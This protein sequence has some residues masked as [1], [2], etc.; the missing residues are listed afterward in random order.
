MTLDPKTWGYQAQIQADN[1]RLE[2]LQTVKQRHQA[3]AGALSLDADGHGTIS[4]PE[5]TATVKVSQLRVQEQT[6]QGLTL[7]ARIHDQVAEINLSSEFAQTPLKGNGT[8]EIKPPYMADLRLD[9][10]RFSFQPLLALYA[11]A[12]AGKVGGQVELHASLRGPLQDPALLEGHLDVPVLTASYQ[13]LQLGAAKPLRV[14]YR[15]G[16]L[17]LQPASLQGTGTNLQLQ[18]TIPVNDPGG[19]TYLVEGAVDLGL[20]RMLQ[21]DL[22]GGGQI[23][24]DLDSRRHAAGSDSIGEVRI[25]N[26]S[27]QSADVPLGLDNGN[28]VLTVSR[29]RL[30]VKSLQGQVGGGTI[31]ATR[32]SNLS[33]RHPI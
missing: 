2:R 1:I 8:V 5:L 15:N 4:S 6:I 10:A 19:A 25:V 12:F 23:Q 29:T 24:I 31:T 16:V 3:I 30:E 11:P 18:A 20:A 21:P 27:L 33:S 26:A 14:D 32:R 17:T 28:G 13:Q 7:A 22:T 9:A